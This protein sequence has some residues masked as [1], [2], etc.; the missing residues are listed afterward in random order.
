VPTNRPPLVHNRIRTLALSLLSLLLSLFDIHS[1]A[2]SRTILSSLPISHHISST[3]DCR[4][5]PQLSS[6]PRWS[7]LTTNFTLHHETPLS[8]LLSSLRTLQPFLILPKALINRL[9]CHKTCFSSCRNPRTPSLQ[10]LFETIATHTLPCL[11]SSINSR[12]ATLRP[13]RQQE[14]PLERRQQRSS[15]SSALSSSPCGI[16]DLTTS[17]LLQ[18]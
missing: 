5:P 12:P 9:L 10:N 15:S 14:R 18:T 16:V 11:P 17:L 13:E 7:K 1:T 4:F 2:G 3:I 8:D 6:L